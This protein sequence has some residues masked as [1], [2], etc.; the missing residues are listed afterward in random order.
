MYMVDPENILALSLITDH[1]SA[2]V[3]LRMQTDGKD[4]WF[5]LASDRSPMLVMLD[6][7]R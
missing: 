7:R 4:Y 6:H 5:V 1:Y 3:D 2:A